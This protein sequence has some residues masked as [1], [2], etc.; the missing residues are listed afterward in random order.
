MNMHATTLKCSGKTATFDETICTQCYYLEDMFFWHR[1][2]IK[3]NF[4][5]NM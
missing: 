3:T 1:F 5:K 2:P 4:V